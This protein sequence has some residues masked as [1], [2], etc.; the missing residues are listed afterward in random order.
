MEVFSVSVCMLIDLLVG[1]VEVSNREGIMKSFW[2]DLS[3]YHKSE[4][5]W[6]ENVFYWKKK[7]KKGLSKWYQQ[8]L[9]LA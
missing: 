9:W 2:E 4:L 7:I 8:H 3:D 1:G 6:K 5:W